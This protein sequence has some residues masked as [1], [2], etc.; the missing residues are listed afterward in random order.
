MKRIA[1]IVLSTCCLIAFNSCSSETEEEYPLDEEAYEPAGPDEDAPR[2]EAEPLK[3]EPVMKTLFLEFLAGSPEGWEEAVMDGSTPIAASD[4]PE[5]D[6][7]SFKVWKDG[8]FYKLQFNGGDEYTVAGIND[9]TNDIRELYMLTETDIQAGDEMGRMLW[10]E[11]ES[12]DLLEVSFLDTWN[13]RVTHRKLFGR[14]CVIYVCHDPVMRLMTLKSIDVVEGLAGFRFVDE[15]N[16]EVLIVDHE[17]DMEKLEG[18]IFK[19]E[20]DGSIFGKYTILPSEPVVVTTQ[21]KVV[22]N[23]MEPTDFYETDV[24]IDLKLNN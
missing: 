7:E 3:L 4:D 13:A 18:V 11:K 24:L 16:I 8:D 5:A 21:K 1:L 14:H 15:Q 22:E 9:E 19:H 6:L 2:E 20:D 17:L 10:L 12:N 23:P